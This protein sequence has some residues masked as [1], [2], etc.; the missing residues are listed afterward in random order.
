[1]DFLKDQQFL[2]EFA[3]YQ[4]DLRDEGIETPLIAAL[5]LGAGG[6]GPPAAGGEG[7]GGSGG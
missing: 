3:E 6:R 7:G 1:M 5:G 2:R 4:L